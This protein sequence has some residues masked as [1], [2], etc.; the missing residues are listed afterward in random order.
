MGIKRRD[1]LMSSAAVV[2]SAAVGASQA[3]AQGAKS[4]PNP[5]PLRIGM[6]D[7]DL[8]ERGNTEKVAL[9]REIGLDGIQ[10][11]I[12]YPEDG[13]LHLRCPKLQAK[14]REAALENGLQICSLAIGD[15]G[16]GEPFKSEPMGVLR[17]AD[18]IEV[19]RNLGAND[20]LL[21]MFRQ[22]VPDFSDEKEVNR[23]VNS[24]KELAPRA[25]KM[26][27][28]ISLETSMSGEE[29]LRILEA[30]AS[31]SVQVYMDP[32]NCAH[33]GHDPLKDISMLKD[34][35]HQVHVKNNPEFM[36]DKCVKGFNWRE[37]AEL[38]YKI[39]YKGWYVLETS[40]PTKD[41]IADTRRNMEYVKKTFRVA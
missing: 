10:V 40:S 29:H 11:S 17:V 38:L 24:L 20:I 5:L 33:Y 2:A 30:V 27:V 41:L 22:R 8:G 4:S 25:E 19:A 21:P 9:A 6:T 23:L 3:S 26:G 28:V 16:P 18:A 32:S 7:W 37:V 15:L 14:Y 36:A 31:R 34:Y 13:S 35:I 1:F 39:G 12:L